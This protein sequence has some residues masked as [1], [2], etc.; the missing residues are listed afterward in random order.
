M[1]RRHTVLFVFIAV[2]TA[3][4]MIA[5][6][7]DMVGGGGQTPLSAALGFNVHS[8]LNGQLNY[9]ADPNGPYAGFSAH[10]SSWSSYTTR[11]VTGG[12]LQV[13]VNGTCTDQDGNVLG[14]HAGFTDRGTPGQGLPDLVCIQFFLGHVL[15]IHDH[16]PMQTGNITIHSD[17]NNA[18]GT[19][20]EMLSS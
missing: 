10:C 14:I 19:M 1:V 3:L 20:A 8:D 11:T 7:A 16:G 9:N 17:P 18:A 15:L 13:I 4:G 12:Y 6:A 5:A 2:F